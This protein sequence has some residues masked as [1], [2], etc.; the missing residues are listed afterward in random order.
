MSIKS[1]LL[2]FCIAQFLI[3]A[4]AGCDG[5]LCKNG[6]VCGMDE[7]N[8]WKG[9]ICYCSPL[10]DG[11]KFYHGKFCEKVEQNP[12]SNNTNPCKNGGKCEVEWWK[13]PVKASC[14]C[15]DLN[16]G[17]KFYYGDF[18]EKVVTGVHF[19]DPY[20]TNDWPNDLK[21]LL[22]LFVN[23]T[24]GSVCQDHLDVEARKTLED[25]ACAGFDRLRSY[26]PIER[27]YPTDG[28]TVQS[29]NCK[30]NENSVL[31]CER[32]MGTV[33]RGNPVYIEC[34]ERRISESG[35]RI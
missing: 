34:S 10:N 9:E 33:C 28:V 21:G 15:Q 27:S 6:A 20:S 3:D 31:E 5:N 2:L 16:H 32:K 24:W 25:V 30:G 8:L 14:N 11:P 4:Q 18:C 17:S 12:C 22:Q 29:I 26:D 19:K 23:G 13:N 35:E 7:K 1:I